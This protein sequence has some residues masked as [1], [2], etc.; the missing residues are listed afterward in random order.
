M[1]NITIATI[2]ISMLFMTKSSLAHT[3]AETTNTCSICDHTFTCILDASGYQSGMR[4]DLKPLGPTPAPWRVPVCPEC[5]F[6]MYDEEI[7]K[8]ELVLCREIIAKDEYKKHA[9]RS[10][11][12]L[13]GLLFEGLGK[14]PDTIGHTFLKASW[15]EEGNAKHLRE[16]MERSLKHFEF[17]LAQEDSVD[18]E[19]YSTA[20]V[21]KGELLRR[22]GRFEES[23]V[24]LREIK[25]NKKFQEG[26]L[27]N[28]IM[29]EIRLCDQE[30]SDPHAISEVE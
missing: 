7:S 18:D 6:V 4:L 20:Q 22:L 24:Y 13:M 1:K 25:E 21:L 28:I 26:I 10:S 30:D 9:E 27:K 15:Q 11:Y 5:H 16:D 12:F 8:K 17:Y 23:G 19:G 29:F 14:G 2:L 3:M